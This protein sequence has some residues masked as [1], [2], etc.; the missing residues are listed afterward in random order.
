MRTCQ[1]PC[2]TKPGRVS[3]HVYAQ[4]PLLTKLDEIIVGRVYIRLSARMPQHVSG[5]VCLEV[6]DAVSA[7]ARPPRPRGVT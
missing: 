6:R 2:V 7:A 4:A 1:A 3:G 5:C